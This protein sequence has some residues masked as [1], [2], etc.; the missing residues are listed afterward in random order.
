MLQ[1]VLDTL[2]KPETAA[3]V[4]KVLDAV[5]PNNNWNV[6]STQC[7]KELQRKLS[8]ERLKEH[9]AELMRKLKAESGHLT[10]DEITYLCLQHCLKYVDLEEDNLP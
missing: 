9:N 2:T 8:G 3:A 5:A 1:E 7:L 4:L 10:E 6:V